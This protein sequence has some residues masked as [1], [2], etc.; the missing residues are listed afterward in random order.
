MC[1]KIVIYVADNPN[2]MFT[3]LTGAQFGDEGKGKVIDLYRRRALE[4][5]YL[6]QQSYQPD[7]ADAG[8]G[9]AA[10]VEAN[11]GAGHVRNPRPERLRR[12]ACC[13]QSNKCCPESN[14]FLLLLGNSFQP[15]CQI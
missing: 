6:E 3:I 11:P 9:E 13:L 1:I 8:G 10:A 5:R 15:L 7:G 14:R 12:G 2:G 4:A